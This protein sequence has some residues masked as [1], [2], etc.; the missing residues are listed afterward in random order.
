MLT[1]KGS[2]D[3]RNRGRHRSRRP[4]N[5]RPVRH[6]PFYLSNLA[7]NYSL[8]IG[9][10][11]VP[12]YASALGM[13]AGEIGTL[14]SA[15]VLAQMVLGLLG[16]ALVDRLGGRRVLSAACSFMLIGGIALLLAQGFWGLVLGQCLIVISRSSFW[17]SSWMLASTMP[18]PHKVFG[19]F[20]A[21]VNSGQ[22][23]GTASAGFILAAGGFKA[24]FATLAALAA[25]ALA[26]SVK[27]PSSERRTGGIDAV[28]RGYREL[29]S[30]RVIY[31]A[32]YSSFL[33]AL[34][35]A[36]S[37]SF[38]PL[39][40]EQLGY[41]TDA[42]GL[43]ISARAVGAV[44]G[45]ILLARWV[46]TGA[47][48]VWSTGWAI[49]TGASAALLP[50]CGN[51]SETLALLL[52]AGAASVAVGIYSQVLMTEATP[53]EQRGLASGLTSQGWVLSLLL[54][55][56]AMGL[57]ADRWGLATAFYAIGTLY[58]ALGVA[59]RPLNRWAYA[60]R[61]PATQP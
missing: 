24:A 10:I 5:S 45:G 25:I 39:L 35:L 58:M 15:P 27:L 20:N 40:L 13:S 17:P 42:S 28:L 49:V 46:H 57:I 21:V 43:L 14:L 38:Y 4:H 41:A 32:V 56:I 36:L 11:A 52:I 2:A 33:S 12:L 22:I 31:F 8:G 3:L 47:G 59:A 51:A 44:A 53:L 16:G 6:W 48:S 55:P 7:W 23:V 34:P 61:R 37:T 19:R 54:V 26:V 9:F 50:L 60:S 30:N 18:E 1:R 29:L